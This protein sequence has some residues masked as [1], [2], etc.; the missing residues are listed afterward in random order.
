VEKM[1]LSSKVK[2]GQ[3]LSSDIFYNDEKEWFKM[4]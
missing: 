4:G 2:F 1:G 3:I